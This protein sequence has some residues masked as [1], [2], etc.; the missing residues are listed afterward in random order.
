VIGTDD[1]LVRIWEAKSGAELLSLSVPAAYY[2]EAKWSP[3]GKYIAVGMDQY[4]GLMV[5]RAWQ[6]TSELLDY[7]KECCVFR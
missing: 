2:S 4:P 1:K 6:S 3:D 7:A 5:L